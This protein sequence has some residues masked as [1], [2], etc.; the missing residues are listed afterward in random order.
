MTHALHIYTTAS[1]IDPWPHPYH[2]QVSHKQISSALCGNRA[3]VTMTL[4]KRKFRTPYFN[5]LLIIYLIGVF[6]R[7]CACL[8]LNVYLC[9]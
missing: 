6:V 2:K 1:A 8:W 7:V 9:V 5:L 4:D 3:M